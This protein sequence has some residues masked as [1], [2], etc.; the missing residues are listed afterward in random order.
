MRINNK[1]VDLQDFENASLEDHEL[2]SRQLLINLQSRI[3]GLA[4]VPGKKSHCLTQTPES[5]VR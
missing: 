3:E 1:S 2:L 5:L 4:N